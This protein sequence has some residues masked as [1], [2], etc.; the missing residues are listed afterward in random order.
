M[1]PYKLWLQHGAGQSGGGVEPQQPQGPGSAAFQKAYQSPGNQDA[2][3]A[4]YRQGIHK[5]HQQGNEQGIAHPKQGE[6]GEEQAEGDPHELQLGAQIELSGVFQFAQGFLKGLQFRIRPPGAE[7]GADPGQLGADHKAGQ[8]G[9]AQAQGLTGEPGEDG[10]CPPQHQTAY[11]GYQLLSVGK[12]SGYGLPVAWQTGPQRQEPVLQQ[13]QPGPD[14]GRNGGQGLTE[15]PQLGYRQSGQKQQQPPQPGNQG[16]YRQSR[17]QEPG[18]TEPALQKVRGPF[19][20]QGQKSAQQEGVH[21]RQHQPQ[22][23]PGGQQSGAE[24]QT[25]FRCRTHM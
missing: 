12:Q 15:A 5:G 19:R 16:P 17:R 13:R 21:Q 25:A 6:P 24:P 22:P 20:A 14:G 4:Q 18:K 1:A 10:P 9:G 2:A 11:L 3:G 8:Q 7:P 23:Q